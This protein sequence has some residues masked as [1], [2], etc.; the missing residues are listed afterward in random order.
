VELMAAIRYHQKMIEAAK[1]AIAKIPPERRDINAITITIGHNDFVR[2][3]EILHDAI[4]K[5]LQLE[6]NSQLRT[7]VYQLNIQLFPFTKPP[8]EKGE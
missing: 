3:I 1:E 8:V 7:D 6:A 2:A 5:I 4:K